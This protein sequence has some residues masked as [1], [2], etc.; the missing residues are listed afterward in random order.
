LTYQL[1]LQF[2]VWPIV[3]GLWGVLALIWDAGKMPEF[4]LLWGGAA[5]SQAFGLMW[6]ESTVE[7]Y[8]MARYIE[9]DLKPMVKAT[10]GNE[11]AF[12]LWEQRINRDRGRVPLVWEWPVAGRDSAWSGGLR[13]TAFRGDVEITLP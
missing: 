4:F 6:Y 7:I 8:Q 12:W 13:S 9:Q 5:L 11:S 10:I 1:T 3:M 2:A